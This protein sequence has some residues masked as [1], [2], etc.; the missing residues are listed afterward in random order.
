MPDGPPEPH[1][2]PVGTSRRVTTYRIARPRA[3]IFPLT[4]DHFE[5]TEYA[6]RRSG[7][8]GRLLNTKDGLIGHSMSNA[9]L[10]EERLSKRVALAVFSS[11]A[12]SSTAYATQEILLVLVIAGTSALTFSL[13]LALAITALLAIVVASYRQTIKA[14]P[15]GGGAYIVGHQN[16][17]VAAG[18]LAAAGLLIGYVLTV[19]VSIAACVEAIVSAAPDIES[20]AVPLAVGLTLLMAFGNLRGLRESG[21]LF[22]IPTY[23]FVA[24]LGATIAIGIAK[25]VI[26]DGENVFAAGDPAKQPEGAAQALTLLL[27][28]RAFAAGCSALTGVEAISNGVTAFKAPEAKNAATTMTA[29]AIILGA[30]FLGTTV[31]TRHFGIVFEHGDQETVMSQMGE[32]IFGR[33]AAYYALQAFTAGILF[34]AANTAFAGFPLL[35][36]ILA[37]DGYLPRLFHQRGNRLVFSYGIGALTAFSIFLLIVFNAN[38]NRLIPLYALGVF[39]SFTIAQSGMVRRWLRLRGP[40]WQRGVAISGLGAIATGVVTVIL[41]ITKFVDGAWMVVLF[42]PIIVIWL[43]RIGAFYKNLTATLRVP[44]QAVF[45]LA[46]RGTSRVPVLVPVEEINLATV[47]ALDAACQRSRD[48]SAVH[49]NFDVEDGDIIIKRWHSQFPNVPLVVIESPFRTV[50]EPFSVYVTDQLRQWPHETTIIV[51]VIHVRHWYQRPLVNQSLRR[52]RTL[53][54]RRKTVE[55]IEQPFSVG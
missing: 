44:E 41:L 12:L 14:Y 26:G 45:E 3:G 27:V 51:P 19:A 8:R 29:M 53:I 33:N 43:W 46:P 18:L 9:R 34:L 10:L 36:A 54:G 11:D 30:L 15:N 49:V 13:P 6:E 17:G 5:A 28:L 48:V 24:V 22:A 1:I 39:L 47:M 50:A 52:L 55:L 2:R 23:G 7:W 37:R 31:L 40:G 32:E 16:L 42:L 4:P 21:T 25:S 38:T 35:T 20:V